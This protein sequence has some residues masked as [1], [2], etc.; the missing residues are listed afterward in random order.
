MSLSLLLLKLFFEE[1]IHVK[2]RQLLLIENVVTDQSY[3][4]IG[5]FYGVLVRMHHG[6]FVDRLAF[7][8]SS[9]DHLL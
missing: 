2:L 1:I 6:C 5:L 9:T 8:F 7:I 4:C 3:V